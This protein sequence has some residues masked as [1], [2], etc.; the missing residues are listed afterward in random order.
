MSVPGRLYRHGLV[1]RAADG[2]VEVVFGA[3]AGADALQVTDGACPGTGCG[4]CPGGLSQQRMD[5][6]SAGLSLVGGVAPGDRVEVSVAAAGLVGIAARAFGVPLA[7]LLAGAWLGDLAG[8]EPYSIALGIFG[9]V[10]GLA[11]LSRSGAKLVGLLEFELHARPL[12]VAPAGP[13]ERDRHGS[14]RGFR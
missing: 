5:V 13:P 7:G 10:A 11:W 1:R 8:G 2:A 6:A 14:L 4:N 12:A 9:L 3:G